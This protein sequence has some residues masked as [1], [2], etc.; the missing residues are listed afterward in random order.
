MDPRS[1]IGNISGKRRGL[2]SYC[3]VPANDCQCR[4]DQTDI[5]VCLSLLKER[6]YILPDKP[7]QF[8]DV[9]ACMTDQ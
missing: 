6:C 8:K 7:R 1:N 5:Y 3:F 2:W 9:Y 4:D